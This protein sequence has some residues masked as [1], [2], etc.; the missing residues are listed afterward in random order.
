MSFNSFTFNLITDVLGFKSPIVLW[1][2]YLSHLFCV[3]FYFLSCLHLD[4]SS[5]YYYFISS[6]ISL[7]VKLNS[8]LLLVVI[9]L[10]I[11]T[12]F[13]DLLKTNIKEI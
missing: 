8:T 5:E 9:L 13:L 6:T 3:P 1:V 4:E 12:F 10:E 2:F 11:T 7:L